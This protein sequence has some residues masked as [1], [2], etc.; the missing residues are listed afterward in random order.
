MLQIFISIA[1]SLG[2]HQ[3]GSKLVIDREIL[4]ETENIAGFHITDIPDQSQI[5]RTNNVMLIEIHGQDQ[6]GEGHH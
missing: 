5:I 2:A 3:Q 1:I 6:N 4:N